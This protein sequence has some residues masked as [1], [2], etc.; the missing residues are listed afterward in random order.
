M[1][2]PGDPEEAILLA[3]LA[4]TTFWLLR[5][6]A[7]SGYAAVVCAAGLA[8]F[9][10]TAHIAFPLL[11]AVYAALALGMARLR[12]V[13][14]SNPSWISLATQLVVI[15]GALGLY[16]GLRMLT[17]GEY[18]DAHANAMRV[19]DLEASLGLRFEQ[20]IQSLTLR[21]L[22]LTR[23]L[24]TLYSYYYLPF[25]GVTLLWLHL[26]HP[27]EY[28][29]MRNAL[30]CSVVFAIVTIALF[31]VAPPRLV[32]ESGMIDT[33][34]FSG[35]EH[36]F[37]NEF[38]AVP[39]LHVGWTALAGYA[40]ALTMRSPLRYLVAVVP[41]LVMLTIVIATGNHYWFDGAIGVAF[42]V[43]PAV[44]MRYNIGRTRL[45]PVYRA[46]ARA[47][48]LAHTVFLGVV[49]TIP[50]SPRALFT[51]VS[52]GAL[53]A[54]L[55]IGQIISPGFT[56]FWGYL[57]AQMLIT[58]VLL[59]VGEWLFRDQGGLSWQTHLI[60]VVCGYADTLGTAGNL[61]A[62]IA[63][64][65]KLTHFA[66]TAA[67]TAGAYDCFRAL[68]RRGNTSAWVESRF[69]TAIAIGVAAGIGWEVYEAVAD[70]IFATKRVQGRLD[71]TYDLI[72]DTLGAIVAAV[73]VRWAER[74]EHAEEPAWGTER[75]P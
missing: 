23:L 30:G 69:L 52:L 26:F 53:L 8:G 42:A 34:V 36:S 55:V 70:D 14:P 27:G 54:F 41:G 18:L 73:M 33:I 28:R 64:Y 71:T 6:V 72:F 48:T 31:P 61:Y 44:V 12:G 59:L 75:I 45:A 50:H 25:I 57:V 7:G 4:V 20:D 29:L 13:P 51:A 11:V 68:A 9:A 63:E 47:A 5:P 32:P 17:E 24:D 39:S 67:V 46:A 21:N 16:I 40:L 2:L 65:D 38:A 66:G 43:I 10:I 58:M 37:S 74:R 49:E 19:L 56:D 3:G 62:N 60:I 15:L 22:D 1:Y 35:R